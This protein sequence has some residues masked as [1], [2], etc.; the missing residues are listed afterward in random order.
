MERRTFITAAGIGTVTALAGCTSSAGE[1]TNV[2]ELHVEQVAQNTIQVSG[3][4]SIETE[5]DKVTFTVSVESSDR[6]DA[7]VVI[8]E[9][10]EQA[11]TL[12]SALLEYGIPEDDITTSRYSL[13]EDSRRNRYEGE[14][15]YLVELDDPDAVGEVIDL[16]AEAGADSVG[17]INFT[18]SEQRQEELYDEAVEEAVAD[19]QSE[20]ELYTETAGQNLQEP[21]SIETT[22]TGHSPFQQRFDYAVAESTGDAAG[23]QIEQGEV[24]VNA[25]VTIEYKFDS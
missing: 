20:A 1:E 16:C 24:S 9:L 21:V 7:S 15:R 22:Q 8:E 2:E 3:T 5:P 11:E 25:E 23:T 12:R 14:H 19:A 10:A 18:L 13:R 4:G 6:D 17:R